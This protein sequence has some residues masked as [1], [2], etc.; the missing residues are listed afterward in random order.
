MKME[1]MREINHLKS[2]FSCVGFITQRNF[3]KRSTAAG[4]YGCQTKEDASPSPFVLSP[5]KLLLCVLGHAE[6]QAVL[7]L[8]AEGWPIGGRGR[9]HLQRLAPQTLLA[10]RNLPHHV[11]ARR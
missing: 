6:S 4:I 10:K 2:S 9:I 1:P 8:P 7:A 3:D 11:P 5:S